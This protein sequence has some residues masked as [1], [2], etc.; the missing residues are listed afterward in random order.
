VIID[1]TIFLALIIE[2]DYNLFNNA[3]PSTTPSSNG[4]NNSCITNKV[5]TITCSKSKSTK[6][7]L[8]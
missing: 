4:Y 7:I 2:I 1:L 5:I 6:I 3:N 8:V